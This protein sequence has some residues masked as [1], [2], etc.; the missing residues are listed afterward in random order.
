MKAF[1][2]DRYGSKDGLRLAE[3]PALRPNDVLVEATPPA[4]ELDR[5]RGRVTT[6]A[7]G[8]R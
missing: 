5:A 1:I 2:L 3:V 8:G 6:D 7:R 4:Q